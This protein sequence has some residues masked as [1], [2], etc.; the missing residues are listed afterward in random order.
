MSM[1]FCSNC[2]K[3]I[4]TPRLNIDLSSIR[5]KLRSESGP[6]SV[7]PDE[8]TSVLQNAQRDLDDYDK[9]THRLESRRMVLIAEKERTREI[10]KQTQCLLAPIRKLPDEI[11]GCI[12]DE[13]CGMNYFNSIGVDPPVD[14]VGLFRTKPA[15]VLSMAHIVT[16]CFNESI[17][18]VTGRTGI[19]D[20]GVTYLGHPNLALHL[21]QRVENWDQDF[22]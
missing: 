1:Q 20:S 15:L 13:C 9:E 4:F 11:L 16:G 8:I 19:S 10:M 17:I 12:F 3:N 6:T 22:V 2:K 14:S 7:Q 5:E 21:A 18:L